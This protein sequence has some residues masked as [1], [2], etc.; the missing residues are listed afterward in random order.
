MLRVGGR[1][2]GVG[3]WGSAAGGRWLVAGG[4]WLVVGGSWSVDGGSNW[5][6]ISN[7]IWCQL[8]LVYLKN[9][10]NQCYQSQ[11]SFQQANLYKTAYAILTVRV[12]CSNL[13]L[14]F[15]YKI[16]KQGLFIEVF[17]VMTH[18]FINKKTVS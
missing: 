15:S 18:L 12:D 2:L 9:V 3:G 5:S 4:R 8:A 7:N 6:Q 16:Q 13:G 17:V 14:V 1:W 11:H 10:S